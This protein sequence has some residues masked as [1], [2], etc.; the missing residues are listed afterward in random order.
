MPGGDS[1]GVQFPKNPSTGKRSTLGAGARTL[2]AA[3]KSIDLATADKISAEADSGSF[4]QSYSKHAVHLA[5]A[6]A[7]DT[8]SIILAAEAGLAHVYEHFEFL[9]GGKPMS[10]QDAMASPASVLHTGR[11]CGNGSL[12][13]KLTV[14]YHGEDLSNEALAAQARA[15]AQYGCLEP[16]AAKAMELA[17]AGADDGA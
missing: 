6:C 8:Q 13:S 16:G 5:G 4:R 9:R 2:A 12:A 15:W 14:S 17:A 1:E 11:V 7:R 3:A 10:L